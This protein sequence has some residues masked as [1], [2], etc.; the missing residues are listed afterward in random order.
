MSRDRISSPQ[1]AS[2]A[3]QSN[4]STYTPPG[5]RPA[6]LNEI[7]EDLK[8]GIESV[9]QQQTMTKSRYMILY[10]LVFCFCFV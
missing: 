5:S 6:S 10:S 7:W 2:F 8:V 1:V 4:S 9:Y 3:S